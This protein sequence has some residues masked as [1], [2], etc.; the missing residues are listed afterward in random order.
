[1]MKLVVAFYI[2]LA[3]ATAWAQGPPSIPIPP[4]YFGMHMNQGPTSFSTTV[5]PP[6]IVGS[7]GK[8]AATNWPYLEPAPGTYDWRPLDRVADFNKR[9]GAPVFEGY[10]EQ[11]KWAVGSNTTGCFVIAGGI[12]SCPAPPVDLFTNA[13]CQ[14]PLAGITTT[15]CMLKEFLTAMVNRYKST[16]TQDGC[17]SSNPQCHGVIEMYEGQN[18]PPYWPGPGGCP[19]GSSCLPIASFVQMESDRLQTIKGIDPSAKVCSPAFGPAATPGGNS[20]DTFIRTFLTNG[21]AS[22][23]YDCWDFHANASRPE[24]QLANINTFKGYLNQYVPG[25]SSGALLYAT[26]A[27]RWEGC[28]AIDSS[29]EQA[30]I[31]RI[32]FLYWSN[33]V[34]RH[35]WYG[36]STCTPLTNQPSS[37]TLTPAGIAY[38]NVEH[39]MVGSTMTSPC[40]LAGRFWSCGLTLANGH[41][42]LAVWLNVFPSTATANYTPGAQFTQYH[43]LSG[44]TGKVSGAL[45]IGESPIL[46]EAVPPAAAP[47]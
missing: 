37:Q 33:N 23:P 40:S 46:L 25:G 35:Y 21:G 26:E 28:K 19:A 15:D 11:P 45:A 36:Y 3:L 39:W 17:T 44:N 8:G 6:M 38:G 24:D 1:M 2:S 29:D 12:S 9:T 10:Q 42:A 14:A 31:G 30:Y 4:D 16:G 34:R 27:G 43:D 18:E 47:K 5:L 20:V 7:G 41:Q 22:I 13:A 32:E